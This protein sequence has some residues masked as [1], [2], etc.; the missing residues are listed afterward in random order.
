MGGV[1]DVDTETLHQVPDAG[2]DEALGD[3]LEEV[4]EHYANRFVVLGK[5]ALHNVEDDPHAG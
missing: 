5:T 1:Q 4:F 3:F 2:V